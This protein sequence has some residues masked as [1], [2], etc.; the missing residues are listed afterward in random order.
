MWMEDPKTNE[1]S[2]TMTLMVVGVLVAILKLLMSGVTINGFAMSTFTG[3]DFA[4]VVAALGGVYGWRKK[5][6]NDSA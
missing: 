1:P 6:D 4:A 2:V 5:M 3:V